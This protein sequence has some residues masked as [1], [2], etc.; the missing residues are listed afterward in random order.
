[1]LLAYQYRQ[2]ELEGEMEEFEKQL[3]RRKAAKG[4]NYE[5]PTS[6]GE[7]PPWQYE[8]EAARSLMSEEKQ[9]QARERMRG[10]TG[11]VS[12]IVRATI[13]KEW[14]ILFT[15]GEVD[16]E[17]TPKEVLEEAKRLSRH[18][19][20]EIRVTVAQIEQDDPDRE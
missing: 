1:M 9:R 7:K 12:R 13:L 16:E 3:R 18:V 8:G 5:P 11:A 20:E 14:H 4:V 10:E 19:L 17:S 2:V 6:E 15:A